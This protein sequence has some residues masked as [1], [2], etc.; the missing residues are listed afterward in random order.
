MHPDPHGV[1]R[2]VTVAFRPRDTREKVLERPPY[3]KDKEPVRL[4]IGIQRL[5]VVQPVEEQ[6][7]GPGDQDD[8]LPTEEF[9]DDHVAQMN[10]NEDKD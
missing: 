5:C 6:G 4:R 3:L 2:T 9:Q 8:V 1:I 7:H 10:P